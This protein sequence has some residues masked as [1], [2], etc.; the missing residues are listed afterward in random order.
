VDDPFT[1][2]ARQ[3]MRSETCPRCDYIW[4]VL[5]INEYGRWS[6]LEDN[7]LICPDCG[8]NLLEDEHEG[9]QVHMH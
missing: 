9:K 7:D 5:G 3:E 1:H 4:D 6:P 2:E 8:R